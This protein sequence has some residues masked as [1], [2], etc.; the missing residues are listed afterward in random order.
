[1]KIKNKK[2]RSPAPFVL[3]LLAG[4][5]FS[6]GGIGRRLMDATETLSPRFLMYFAVAI[7]FLNI[8]KLVCFIATL[9]SMHKRFMFY[10]LGAQIL[11]SILSLSQELL[12]GCEFFYAAIQR[13]IVLGVFLWIYAFAVDRFGSKEKTASF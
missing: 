3:L 13:I 12:L 8:C 9:T 4:T 6:F 2:K 5:F 11:M 10:A 7:L 1:M